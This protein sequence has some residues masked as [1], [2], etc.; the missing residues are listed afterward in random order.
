MRS[1]ETIDQRSLAM[2]RAIV[3]KIDADPAR[4][5]LEHAREVCRNWVSAGNRPAMEWSVIM[6]LPW[7][8]IRTILLD[9]SE[10]GQRLRQSDPFCG[11]LSPE[12]RWTIYREFEER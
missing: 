8:E 10:E 12:E 3:A 9:E 6:A 4:T 7:E 5:G 11:I 2:V 1:H